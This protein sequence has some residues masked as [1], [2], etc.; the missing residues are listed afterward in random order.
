MGWALGHE[1]T[2][3]TK[4]TPSAARTIESFA[5][6]SGELLGEA[7][8]LTPADVRAGVERARVAQRAWGALPVEER[9]ER[10]LRFRDALVERAE[11]LVELL[12]KETGKPRQEALGHELLAL[13][14]LM[15][16]HAKNAPRILAPREIPLHLLKHRKSVVH[17]VPRGV[18][19]VI[20]P[21]NFPLI[22]PFADAF[23]ALITGSAVVVKPS[24]VTP[25]IA[26]RVKDVW[27]KSGLPED[28]LQVVTGYAETGAALIDAG[29]QKLVFTGGVASGKKVAA[30]CG[31]RLI[32]CVM[33]LG[34][35]APLI[36][37]A[38]ADIERTARAIT[39]GGF[40]NSGQACIS[41]ERVYAHRDIYPK[42]V[43]RVTELVK[44]LRQ[45]NGAEETVDVGAII[46]PKQI[47][48]AERHI[49]DA[50]AKGA[51]LKT[52]GKRRT[53]PGQFFEPT[54]LVDCTPDMSVMREEI[55]GPIVP[56]MPVD[57]EEQA[58]TLANDSPLGLNAYVFTNSRDLA[59]N[60]SE[61]I[62]AGSVVVNDVFTNYA[63]PEA[64]FGGIKHSG[65]GRI[66]GEDALRD[67]AEVKHVNSDRFRPPA[68]DPLWF[69]YSEK[70]YR[71]GLRGLRAMFSG[72]GLIARVRELL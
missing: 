6:A 49:A 33:E 52:G 19:G 5:P 55:F 17:Y 31:E 43:A 23:A 66:H 15:T 64:P 54:L 61:R 35:K 27:D 3:R 47:D 38:D 65:F 71:W 25:L 42:L 13:A 59:A 12:S 30:A 46:F 28:L 14:D 24:E 29:I 72:Q 18:I 9:C 53:G 56:M 22:I 67:L 4:Q 8:V 48:V 62:E 45:G 16:W 57:N 26:L 51:E 70:G 34:G 63:C 37:C 21:W 58:V 39:F 69:P 50:L 40:A 36:A 1:T 41:V 10:L 32:P 60:L 68:R 7:P 11:E 44:E 20:S 2:E